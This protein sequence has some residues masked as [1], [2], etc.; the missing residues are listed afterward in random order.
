YGSAADAVPGFQ[1]ANAVRSEA[2][3]D[4]GSTAPTTTSTERSGVSH[5]SWKRT[6]SSRV[7]A[8]TLGSQPITG[9]PMA[10]PSQNQ[11]VIWLSATVDGSLLSDA[12]WPSASSRFRLNSSSANVGETT[13]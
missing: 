9:C 11:R 6:T 2:S 1:P 5:A 8:L 12:I 3:S 4:A 7:S 10:L 13:T